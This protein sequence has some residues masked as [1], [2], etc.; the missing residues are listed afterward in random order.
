MTYEQSKKDYERVKRGHDRL[1]K[2]IKKG[3]V[4]RENDATLKKLN[5]KRKEL[6]EEYNK[7]NEA[8]YKRED[9]LYEPYH[10]YTEQLHDR[11]NMYGADAMQEAEKLWQKAKEKKLSAE[12]AKTGVYSVEE[13]HAYLRGKY[14][15]INSLWDERWEKDG[16]FY[17]KAKL[18]N[19]VVIFHNKALDHYSW[20]SN[21]DGYNTY[22]AFKRG[23]HFATWRKERS[24]H[25]GDW[26]ADSQSN[27]GKE[28][29][30]GLKFHEW[31]A[32]LNEVK[33]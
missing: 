3:E 22:Y 27:I 17:E 12:V 9:K 14:D 18:K 30:Q 26:V 15:R 16:Y 29:F 28:E 13:A 5:K 2:N 1:Q 7:A 6:Q 4:A 33:P 19:G 11:K 32:K 21:S 24:L 10:K 8:V 31:K 20:H 25:A 23:K